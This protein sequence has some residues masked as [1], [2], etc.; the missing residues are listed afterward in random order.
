MHC[1]YYVIYRKVKCT[2]YKGT[3][4]F[5]FKA[6]VIYHWLPGD[7]SNT[8]KTG[9]TGRR[10]IMYYLSKQKPN[11]INLRS[12]GNYIKV[13]FLVEESRAGIMIL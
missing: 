12:N 2:L 4:K 3:E 13:T 6:N 11:S 10:L 5:H 1:S 8:S 7:I 9:V